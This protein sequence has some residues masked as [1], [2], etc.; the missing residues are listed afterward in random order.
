MVSK[1]IDLWS[2]KIKQ[3]Y[4]SYLTKATEKIEYEIQELQAICKGK[5]KGDSVVKEC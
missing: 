4:E 5:I 3:E 1:C 2:S